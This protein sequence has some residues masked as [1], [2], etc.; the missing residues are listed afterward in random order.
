[1]LWS[2]DVVLQYE[3]LEFFSGTGNVSKVFR[4]AGKFVCPYEYLDNPRT[5]DFLTH[6]GFAYH[7]CMHVV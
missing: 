2:S 3:M 5:M 7:V 4:E 6:S 1:M